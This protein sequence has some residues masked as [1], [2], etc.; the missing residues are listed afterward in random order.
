MFILIFDGLQKASCIGESVYNP[1]TVGVIKR[2]ICG[3]FRDKALPQACVIL[4]AV[5]RVPT[6]RRFT[7]PHSKFACHLKFTR[8]ATNT[9]G[10][11]GDT[12]IH[13][14]DTGRV[15]WLSLVD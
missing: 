8:L 15:L 5:S 12:D 9:G 4:A 2:M 10:R 11:V 14:D 3:C 1:S 7:L 6:T 13:D